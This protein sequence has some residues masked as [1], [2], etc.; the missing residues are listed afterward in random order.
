MTDTKREVT[1]L[2]KWLTKLTTHMM[3]AAR[4]PKQNVTDFVKRQRELSARNVPRTLWDSRKK[5]IYI[6]KLHGA[7]V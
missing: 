2:E 3:P 1:R 4:E 6:R 7:L 5:G